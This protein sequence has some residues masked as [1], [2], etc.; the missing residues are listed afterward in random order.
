M[1]L[2]IERDAL[3][4]ALKA[5]AGV[6]EKKT[7]M[8]IVQHVRIKT[9]SKTAA[10][11]ATDLD[12]EVTRK[13]D[14]NVIEGG[15]ICLRADVLNEIARKAPADAAI[16]IETKDN[17]KA[18]VS[19]KRSRFTLDTLPADDFPDMKAEAFAV[20]FKI[21]GAKLLS[22]FGRTAFAI[23]T[24]ETRHYLNGAYLH[25]VKAQLRAVA[26]DGHTLARITLDGLDDLKSLPGVIVPA[27]AVAFLPKAFAPDCDLIVSV[28]ETKVKITNGET[29]MLTKTIDGTF[30]D[31][32]RIIPRDPDKTLT[33]D[34]TA[35][36]DALE[37][38]SIIGSERSRAVT[39]ELLSGKLKLSIV[40]AEGGA[41]QE[42]LA[43][44]HDADGFKIAMNYKYLLS[45][46][47]TADGPKVTFKFS[48]PSSP[49][50]VTGAGE[51]ATFICMPMRTGG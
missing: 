34:R 30:P 40:N 45:I 1:K 24:E 37:R 23:S 41:A 39:L 42:D 5:T 3:I 25:A 15:T 47:A 49:V 14:V 6:V 7:T 10:F 48:D 12:M 43:A 11:T 21:E 51:E 19:A 29:V 8:P 20:S 2:T 33:V 4:N 18:I 9:N 32:E 46:L 22:L 28:S 17:G 27:K 38:V 31:Y 26:T 35:F 13:A 36:E 50:L 16:T 44:E